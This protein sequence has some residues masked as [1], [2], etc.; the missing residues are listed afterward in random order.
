M[1]TEQPIPVLDDQER[2]QSVDKR[3]MRRLIR[4]L[5]EQCETA[6]GIGRGFAMEPLAA[7]P[8]VVFIT[9]VGDSA[10]AGDM[11]A[12]SAGEDS[13]VP[14]ISDA[15]GRIPGYV[16][17]NSL[18]F[19]V[20]YTGKSQT[21]LRNYREAR[22]RNATVICVTSGGKLHEA[23]AKDG[24]RTV[25]IPPGQPSR[26]AIGYLYIP[27]VAVLEQLGL[28]SGAV[29]KLS[30]AIRLLKNVRESIRF[31]NPTARNVAK[32]TA[33]A[34]A[35]KIPAIYGASGYRAA[36]ADRWRS[37][38]AANSKSPA[39]SGLF[40]GVADGD[41]CAWESTRI[42]EVPLGF[43]FLTDAADKTTELSDTMAACGQ[44]LDK[45]GVTEVEMKGGTAYEKL[46]YGMYLGDFVS[47][48]L[49]IIHG[50][51][52]WVTESVTFV[53]AQLEGESAE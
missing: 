24:G 34:I 7:E 20:D 39:F 36:I 18:V 22:L 48:Y 29:E 44:L 9:G 13:V 35:D 21:A 42:E 11:V 12:V 4:E 23:C 1:D 2:L 27:I 43:V 25:R 40:P 51:N 16:T 49:A 50:V 47:Y 15:G 17:E 8:N 30:Y 38:I 46:L 26:T 41:I 53:E 14:V 33:V 37:Q 52:P 31:S 3:D 45:F 10:I 6:L 19:V 32:Q 5:P 28:V